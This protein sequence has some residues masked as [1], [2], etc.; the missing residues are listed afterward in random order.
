MQTASLSIDHYA[1]DLCRLPPDFD[2]DALALETKAIERR[3]EVSDGSSCCGWLS[4]AA[5]GACH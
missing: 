3:R 5:P 4:L 1:D 2:L